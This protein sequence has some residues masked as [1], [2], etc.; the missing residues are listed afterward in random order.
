MISARLPSVRYS[1]L[2]VTYAALGAVYLA[3][4]T[5]LS[6]GQWIERHG[7]AV[8][9]NSEDTHSAAALQRMTP[10]EFREAQAIAEG[11]FARDPLDPTTLRELGRMAEASDRPEVA[12]RLKLI[13]G[14]LT[15][16]STS[17]QVDAL[18]ILLARE[19]FAGALDRIDGLMRAHP[20]MAKQYLALIA[21]IS[22]HPEGRRAVAITLAR[23]PPW[24][25]SLFSALLAER[26]PDVVAR[27][28]A[29][30]KRAGG[31]EDPR[32]LA[33]LIDYYVKSGDIDRGY[34][35]WLSSLSDGEMSDVRRIYDGDFKYQPKSLQFDWTIKPAE[36][37]SFRRFPRNTSNLDQTLQLEF[38]GA[39][40]PFDNLSQILRLS[41]GRYRLS[42]EAHFGNFDQRSD[43]KFHL[44]CLAKGNSK[45]L[46]ETPA[47]PQSTQWMSFAADFSV[48]AGDCP[49]QLL[50][51]EAKAVD[52]NGNGLRGVLALD[53][54]AIDRIPDLV[55]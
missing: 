47:L 52:P 20:N 42:G 18:A 36:G 13:A 48:T 27:L 45:P 41:P 50:R 8:T 55:P 22:G 28:L 21:E 49:H 5:Y 16:R 35:A 31:A 25:A 32:E 51:L 11:R 19:D 43:F 40:G 26:Q 9:A 30:V 24:R 39:R 6:V 23:D 17:V 54:I 12:E 4:C 10:G 44:Y 1:P 2:S 14:D 37:F 53:K 33:R 29:E 7:R 38:A 15:P 3:A 46:D 34:A